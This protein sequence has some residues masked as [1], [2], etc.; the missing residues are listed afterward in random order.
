MLQNTAQNLRI[1][2]N[3]LN[4]FLIQNYW[5]ETQKTGEYGR[6]YF[7]GILVNLNFISEPAQLKF[8]LIS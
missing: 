7:L 8:C 4:L 6:Q 1:R 5:N 3:M 2:F